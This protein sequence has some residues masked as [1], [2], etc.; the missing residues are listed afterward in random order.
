MEGFDSFGAPPPPPPPPQAQDDFDF[1]MCTF[2]RARA[3]NARVALRHPQ[4]ST[5]LSEAAE[6]A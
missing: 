6:S 1:G 4:C 5:A 2:A 3:A